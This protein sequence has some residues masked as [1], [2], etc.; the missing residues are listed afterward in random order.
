MQTRLRLRQLPRRTLRLVHKMQQKKTSPREKK[1]VPRAKATRRRPRKASRTLAPS[2]KARS[3]RPRPVDRRRGPSSSTGPRATPKREAGARM[4]SQSR[5]ATLQTP[6][7]L[8]RSSLQGSTAR[9]KELALVAT[10]SLGTGQRVPRLEKAVL[11]KRTELLILKAPPE[12]N[13]TKMAK[14]IKMEKIK[15]HI[16]QPTRKGQEMMMRKK[17]RRKTYQ[18]ILFTRIPWSSRRPRSS[19]PNGRSTDLVIGDEAAARRS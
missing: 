11:L 10:R 12:P 19:S 18:R 4:G 14:M 15:R 16:G 8:T 9:G 3:K 17:M 6:S 13:L 1:G 5:L 2:R 7:R